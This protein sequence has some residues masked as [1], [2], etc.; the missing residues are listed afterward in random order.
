[1]NNFIL[2]GFFCDIIR[3][4]KKLPVLIIDFEQAKVCW[5]YI[6]KINTFE[7][8]IR[9][10]MRLCCSNLSVTKIYL[11]IAFEVITLGVNQW[12]IF[13]KEFTSDVDSC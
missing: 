2:R 8:K 5:V 10:I 1:M 13:T 3:L 9:Y 7:D 6:E 11:Q 12:E 4:Y